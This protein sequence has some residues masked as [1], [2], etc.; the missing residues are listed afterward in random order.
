VAGLLRPLSRS[1]PPL[2]APAQRVS[3]TGLS[4]VD[5]DVVA[6][7]PHSLRPVGGCG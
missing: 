7:L 6:N 4:A 3:C 5:A 2:Q 1:T